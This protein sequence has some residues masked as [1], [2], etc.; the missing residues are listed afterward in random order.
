MVERF[1]EY[2]KGATF[3]DLDGTLLITNSMH[4]FMR[5]MPW[6]LLCRRS[7]GACIASLWWMAMRSARVISHRSMKWHLTRI[8]ARHYMDSDWKKLAEKLAKYVNP[9]VREYVEAPRLKNC[10]VYIATAA[11]EEYAI[12]LS[13]VLG[14]DGA[15]AT[16]LSEKK[17]DY[18]EMRGRE[19]LDGISALLEKEGLRLESF[20]T[21]HYDDIPTASA[22]PGFTILVNPSRRMADIFRHSGVTRYL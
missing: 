4:V 3:V 12:P 9:R 13:R 6:T 5:R 10:A 22:Y 14:Y 18:T 1:Q 7:L 2:A 16:R 15:I 11:P 21:D 17:S 19:K 8:A 20:L